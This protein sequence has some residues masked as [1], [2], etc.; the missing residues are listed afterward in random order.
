M[1]K[2]CEFLILFVMI[3]LPSAS[4]YAANDLDVLTA[5]FPELK[6]IQADNSTVR[7]AQENWN[8]ARQ[9]VATDASWKAWVR[10]SRSGLD[11]WI[12]KTRD[13]S[14][15]IAGYKHDL[16]DPL[17]KLPIRW[18]V[19]MPEP[20]VKTKSDQR[21]HRA[22]VGWVRT[23]NFNKILEAS[24][25][26]R[27][28]DDLR[29]AEW[30]ASQLD[31][32]AENY[33]RWPLQQL[34]ASPSRM[35]GT[36][37][38]EAMATVN[39]IDAVRLLKDF[40]SK[41]R[42]GTWR[43]KLFLPIIVNLR[44]AE[45]GIN[46]ISLWNAAAMAEIA[47][48]FEDGSMYQESI[49]G[50]KGIRAIMKVG[51]TNDF[52]WY[53]GSLNYQTYV[54]RA[55]APLFIQAS[56]LGRGDDLIREMIISQNMLLAPIALRFDDGMLPNP[57][58]STSRLKAVDI[59]FHL[60]MYRT[61]PTRI[62]LIQASYKKNWDTLL[63]PVNVDLTGATTMPIVR[64]VNLDSVRMSLLKSDGW[65][66]FHRYG[67]LT[68]HH[69]QEDALNIEIYYQD[70]PLSTDPATVFYETSLHKDYFHRAI[71]HN[72]PLVDGQ[73][74]VGWSAGEINKFD[75]KTSSLVTSQPQYRP[76]AS[77]TREISIQN[78]QLLDRVNLRLKPEVPGEKRLGFLFHSDCKIELIKEKMGPETD[79]APP[80]GNGF[81]FWEKVIV[82][83]SPKDAQARFYCE[84][85]EFV[86]DL[87]MSSVSRI[88]TA[89]TPSTPLPKMRSVIYVEITGRDASVEMKLRLLRQFPKGS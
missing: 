71:S 43:E 54:L 46:N 38:D 69:S 68:I 29:Y 67:Q 60:E 56:L 44:N 2:W 40:S 24:R 10:S 72:V 52:I 4:V 23:N 19:S 1:K 51:V 84:G 11:E 3:M 61:L 22:W 77:A 33:A 57:G 7:F 55:L 49:N 20:S 27:L 78:S 48:E 74:Q 42:R 21:F 25:M 26:Y 30:A 47:L 15:W 32:Y 9:L 79:A 39:L 35:M 82:R 8:Q 63:D 65:Q 76:D 53:E 28:T 41:E 81:S 13:Q 12:S 31:F 6:V 18:L 70:V 64:S 62:G 58:D 16:I 36:G 85:A 66:V 17:T 83:K 89:M 34:H 86:A 5:R 45:V 14:A 50:P 80:I 88:Y 37:L 73:G 75:V 87:R 59:A